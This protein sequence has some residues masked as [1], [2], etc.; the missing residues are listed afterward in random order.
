[1]PTAGLDWTVCRCEEK[2]ED[3]EWIVCALRSKAKVLQEGLKKVQGKHAREV[4]G[5]QAGLKM[6]GGG[7][8]GYLTWQGLSSQCPAKTGRGKLL[9]AGLYLPTVK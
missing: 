6:V 1:M 8:P 3:Q 4:E 2:T 9:T 5:L 7:S